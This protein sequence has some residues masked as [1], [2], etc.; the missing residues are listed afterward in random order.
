MLILLW[1]V[2]VGLLVAVVGLICRLVSDFCGRRTTSTI[3]Y[4]PRGDRVL[5]S[6]LPPPEPKEGM[7]FIPASQQKPLNEA[8]VVVVGPGLRNRTT[9]KID[10]VDLDPG[11]IVCFVDYAGFEVEVDGVKYLSLRDE[12]IHGRRLLSHKILF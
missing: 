2:A 3:N 12:E 9:G 6:R 11:D 8:T 5:V 10:P 7:V 4:E 1:V